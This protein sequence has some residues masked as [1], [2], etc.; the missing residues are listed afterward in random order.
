MWPGLIL[1]SCDPAV[2]NYTTGASEVGVC[3]RFA[4][5]VD[6]NL[7]TLTRGMGMGC[8]CPE[9]HQ[10][11]NHDFLNFVLK[12]W[13][14]SKKTGI[15]WSLQIANHGIWIRIP[16][17]IPSFFDYNQ[18]VSFSLSWQNRRRTS[19]CKHGKNF[20]QHGNNPSKNRSRNFS[21]S[22][23]WRTLHERKLC[24]EITSEG[25]HMATILFWI[26]RGFI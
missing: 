12:S 8:G 24:N 9:W 21:N 1:A 13:W 14:C 26:L 22:T 23:F 7:P 20:V 18:I 5:S 6:S 2:F 16:T 10:V 3:V 11:I 4:K 25:F 17:V 19:S 15:L